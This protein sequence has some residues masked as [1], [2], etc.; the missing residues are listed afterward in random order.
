MTYYYNKKC[1]DILFFK[2]REKVFLL[3][4]N[5]KTK[6]LNKKLDYKKLRLFKIEKKIEKLS[7]RL[8][9]S[10]KMRIHSVFHVLLLKKTN[11]NTKQY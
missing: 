1:K 10:H 11:Q 5:I 3:Q 6:Q 9:L 8:K 4:Q 7:Y 2:K